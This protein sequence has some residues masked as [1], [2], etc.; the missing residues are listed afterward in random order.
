MVRAAV[1]VAVLSCAVFAHPADAQSPEGGTLTG[2]VTF[3]GIRPAPKIYD[4][5]KFPNTRF[6]AKADSDGRGNRVIQE[7]NVGEG[8]SLRDVV[9]AVQDAPTN[10]PFDF[11][12][13]KVINK[14]CKWL[15]QG[16][17]STF[18]GVV[19]KGA[20][21]EITNMDA[22]PDDPKAVTGVLHS[23][24]VYEMNGKMIT[25][26]FNLPLPEK[27]Q[28]TRK[29]VILRKP[30]SILLLEGDQQ[31]FTRAFFL[32]VENPHYAI[33]ENDGT[34]TIRDIPP[35]TY[36]VLAWHPIL[37]KQEKTVTISASGQARA[38]FS[39]GVQ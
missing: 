4:L 28:S 12:G 29:V 27:G 1:L 17:P 25:S 35:G 32:P 39:F 8:H 3:E 5:S 15:V 2:K 34:F 37:G 7:V 38:D 30:N 9:I 6:C 13:T 21:I 23:P 20:E 31:N 22:D 33:V 24:H 10:E 19:V 36:K 26:I 18:V 16:G 11:K 14:G